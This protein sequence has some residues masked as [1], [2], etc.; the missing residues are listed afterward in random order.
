MCSTSDA[1]GA[2]G[3][4]KGNPAQAV[5]LKLD[6]GALHKARVVRIAAGENHDLALTSKGEVCCF[7]CESVCECV[8]VCVSL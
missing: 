2:I 3:F 5:P 1:S 4:S 7:L 6:G 8:C